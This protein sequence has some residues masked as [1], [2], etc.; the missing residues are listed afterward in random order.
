MFTSKI[1]TALALCGGLAACGNS[2][3]EQAIIGGAVGAGTAAVVGG[4][5]ATGVAVGAA[6]NLLYCQTFPSKCN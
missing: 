3:S 6:G 5:V 1:F 2:V 4:S